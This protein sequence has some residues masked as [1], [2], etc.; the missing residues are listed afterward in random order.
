ME[1][2]RLVRDKKF[3]LGTV[4]M[5]STLK[6]EFGDNQVAEVTKAL[7]RHQSG[8]WGDVD[9]HDRYVNEQALETG[10]RIMSVYQS[11]EG[12]RFYVI[13][14]WDRSVTTLLLPEDY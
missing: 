8:D 2:L 5:T 4:V 3:D 6:H 12:K 7:T 13:T 9:E 11:I 14:E 10:S 1:T